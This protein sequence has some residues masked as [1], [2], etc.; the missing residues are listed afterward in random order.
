M[1]Q[2]M[3]CMAYKAAILLN[4][5]VVLLAEVLRCVSWSI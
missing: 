4:S 2:I 1:I 3:I 5:I